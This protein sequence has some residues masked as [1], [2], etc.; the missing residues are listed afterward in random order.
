MREFFNWFISET[1][2]VISPKFYRVISPYYHY[3][4]SLLAALF[5]RFPSRKLFVVGVT[6]TKGKTTTIEIIN[7]V[8][9]EAGYR[10]A[11]ASTLRLK[12][13][14]RSQRN[15]YKMTMPGRFFLQKFLRDAAKAHC[16]H[17]ILEM[18]S[19]GAQQFRHTY[20]ELDALIFTNL[21]P[22]HIK[23]HGS[24]ENYRAAKLRLVR[25]LTES[26][27][28]P[29]YLVVNR[30]DQEA[31]KFLDSA[32][33]QKMTFGLSDAQP[34]RLTPFGSECMWQ[35][36][37]IK[38]NL[39]G[40]FNIYNVLAAGTLAR[41]MGIAKKTIV[42]ALEKLIAVPGRVEEITKKGALF[43]VFVD[44]AHTAESLE[45]VYKALGPGP[46]LCVLG[47]TG[48]GRDSWKRPVMGG[49]AAEY[50]TDIILT[51]E[52]P[53]DESPFEII[54]EIQGGI[55]KKVKILE[56]AGRPAP[57]STII[58]ERR[59]A[60]AEALRRAQPGTTVIITGKGTDPYIM[61]PKGSKMPWSD[62]EVVREGLARLFSSQTAR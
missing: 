1:K 5:Y 44:Y 50:C 49:I 30:D 36:E 31:E 13:G 3:A 19:E 32:V 14:E 56:A 41:A 12:M 55:D 24:Y 4:L 58:M 2:A 47:G 35:G 27:K 62:E 22:E 61:G 37:K 57:V 8:F 42:T 9:E 11:I 52:D 45:A 39:I 38:I 29:R 53:Y 7:A 59:D 43:R 25:A 20:I 23:S 16:T 15:L 60:I 51:N 28:R 10:T 54:R 40:E 26:P 34:F 18:T 21:A 6:G 48:G 46:R 33:E 17:A